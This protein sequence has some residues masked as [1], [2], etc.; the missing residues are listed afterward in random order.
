MRHADFILTTILAGIAI[1][2]IEI[3][4]FVIA[5]VIFNLVL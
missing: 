3:N 2:E 5:Q 4:I 1:V